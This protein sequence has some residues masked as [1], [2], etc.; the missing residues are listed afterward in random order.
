MADDKKADPRSLDTARREAQRTRVPQPVKNAAGKVL[1]YVD[2]SGAVVPTQIALDAR[3]RADNKSSS[4]G[5]LGGNLNADGGLTTKA[6]RDASA[7]VTSR[8]KA[9]PQQIW[10]DGQLVTIQA[11]ENGN[12]TT[13]AVKGGA[14]DTMVRP[15]AFD[16]L[17]GNEVDPK[18]GFLMGYTPGTGER[19]V[20]K[21]NMMTVGGAAAWL[22]SL[23]TK[24][25]DAYGAMLEKLR[26]AGYLSNADLIAAAGR[27]SSA[28]GTAFTLAARDLA[29]INTTEQGRGETL[30]QF[31]NEK[32]GVYD[33]SEE[34]GGKPEYVPVARSYTD[35]EDLKAA[36]KGAAE[37]VLGRQL[38]DEEEAK[39]T[40]RFRGLEDAAYDKIDAAGRDGTVGARYT[41]PGMG[42][43]DAFVEGPEYE[44]EVADFAAAGYGQ[45]LK[46][47]FGVATGG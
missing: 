31:L 21:K 8:P 1:Y 45:A 37:D 34:G 36:A 39:L 32:Q 13:T 5:N 17:D 30:A 26:N 16:A 9:G 10:L 11:D 18:A 46:R 28:A 19:P 43:V 38:T 47:L 42:Q 22:A 23:S 6:E 25:K 14:Q 12:W 4:G 27:W 7:I 29:V 3:K 2:Y 33:A 15:T 40:A 24:D 44:Q 41:A 20:A 35:P